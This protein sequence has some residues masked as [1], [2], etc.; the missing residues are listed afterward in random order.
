MYRE[1]LPP[2]SY[3]YK[4]DSKGYALLRPWGTRPTHPVDMDSTQELDIIIVGAGLAGWSSLKFH[5]LG[6]HVLLG[7]SAL[8]RVRQELPNASVAVFEKRNHVGGTWAKNTYPGLSC[9]IPSQ[10]RNQC[11]LAPPLPVLQGK[12]TDNI[13]G[14]STRIHLL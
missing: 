2:E 8:T 10:V 5:R 3:Y 7:I 1:R 11:Q 6:A 14:S 4:E 9:D 12:L 13:M